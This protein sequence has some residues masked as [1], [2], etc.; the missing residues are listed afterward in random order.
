MSSF[1]PAASLACVICIYSVC[2]KIVAMLV[3]N[4]DFWATKF[5]LPNFAQRK[6]R[7]PA[8]VVVAVAVIVVPCCCRCTAVLFGGKN[9]VPLFMMLIE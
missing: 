3:S 7:I 2:D 9:C 5:L 8:A 4:L 6:G 1:L